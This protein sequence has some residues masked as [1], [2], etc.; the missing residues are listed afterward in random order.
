MSPIKKYGEDVN[1]NVKCIG[2]LGSRRTCQA[3]QM[4]RGSLLIDYKRIPSDLKGKVPVI[5]D[6]RGKRCIGIY[7]SSSGD[8]ARVLNEN[9]NPIGACIPFPSGR[10]DS[11]EF[12]SNLFECLRQ[13]YGARGKK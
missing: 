8:T 6:Y 11:P 13:Q 3:E 7:I 4:P 1:G 2:I 9:Y 12:I 5:L 10:Q